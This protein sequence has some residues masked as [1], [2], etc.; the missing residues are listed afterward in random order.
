[1]ARIAKYVEIKLCNTCNR[2]VHYKKFRSIKPLEKGPNKGKLV[3]WTDIDRGTRASR[4]KDCEKNLSNKKYRQNPIPQLIFAFKNRAKK[5]KVPFD[6][7]IEDISDLLQK[8]GN[9]CPVLGLKMS[10]SVLGS[11]DSNY[12][13]SFDRIYPKKGYTKS[14]IVIVSNRANRIKSDATVDEIRKVADFYEK[15]LKNK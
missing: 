9:K 14:N 11:G 6:L 7:T 15:L 13:P 8:A 3:G 12:S 4:C 10:T 1:M 2:N 5:Q